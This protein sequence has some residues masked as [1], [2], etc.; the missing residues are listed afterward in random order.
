MR[1]LSGLVLLTGIGVGVFV[2][3]PAPVDSRTTLDRVTRT[4]QGRTSAKHATGVAS[5]QEPLRSFSP[6]IPLVM[7]K[8]TRNVIAKRQVPAP[9]P[10]SAA[11]SARVQT[12]ALTTIDQPTT[13]DWKTVARSTPGVP[14]P[15]A[16]LKSLKPKTA[17]A[18]YK[19]VVDLQRALKD[20]RCYGG[21]I[22]GAWGP[23]SKYAMSEF[24][25]RIN[26]A[27][28]VE[29]PD[30]VLLSLLQANKGRRCD[31]CPDGQTLSVNGRCMTNEIVAR[32]ARVPSP[33]PTASETLPWQTE[34]AAV[35]APR[36]A[37]R[38]PFTP[39]G[40]TVISNSNR[41]L[42]GRMAIGGPKPF[43]ADGPT[44]PL[45]S[46]SGGPET[47]SAALSE[48]DAGWRPSRSV[49]PRTQKKKAAKPRKTKRRRAR[50]AR[51]T[52]N[53]YMLQSL[54]GL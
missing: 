30:Y 13:G 38:S 45:I 42:P 17:A 1:S 16:A 39:V 7:P 20:A 10:N 21:R 48:E 29:D 50:V 34:V 9:R 5:I 27:L 12:V 44:E 18:R 14:A 47:R 25:K 28:P 54:G 53:Y 22:D 8:P 43:P 3:L 26:A 31:K 35:P 19:L 11:P 52:P 15:K 36:P 46:G 23:G 51:G 32:G 40:T 37:S 41:V 6:A 33:A 4:F 49:T 24:T 2:Y